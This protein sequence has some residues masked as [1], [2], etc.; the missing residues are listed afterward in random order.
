MSRRIDITHF[1]GQSPR[2]FATGQLIDSDNVRLH[3]DHAVE[4]LEAAIDL[5]G[6]QGAEWLPPGVY[7][8]SDYYDADYETPVTKEWV[9]AHVAPLSTLGADGFKGDFR[10]LVAPTAEYG[11][12][13]AGY[14][15][16]VAA[17]CHGDELCIVYSTAMNVIDERYETVLDGF[18]DGMAAT[19]DATLNAKTG[20]GITAYTLTQ[21][22]MDRYLP[23]GKVKTQLIECTWNKHTA[24]RTKSLLHRTLVAPKN[25]EFHYVTDTYR[26]AIGIYSPY[27]DTLYTTCYPTLAADYP[28]HTMGYFERSRKAGFCLY[29]GTD[30]KLGVSRRFLLLP[31]LV[32][33]TG[34]GGETD[35]TATSIQS[36]IALNAGVQL[37]GRLYGI[38]E[39][40][41]HA[42]ACGTADS[43]A[44]S[45][46]VSDDPRAAWCDT[47]TGTDENFTAIAAF[48]GKIIAFTARSMLTV[49]GQELPFELSYIGAYGCLSAEALA[50]HEKY[51]FFVSDSGVMRYDGTHITALDAPPEPGSYANAALTCIGDLLLLSLPA[52]DGIRIYDIAGGGWSYRRIPS[53]VSLLF[54]GDNR[55]SVHFR[56]VV[57]QD[58]GE[59]A[60]P[61]HLFGADGAFS[62]SVAVGFAGRQ[63][64]HSISVTAAPEKDAVLSVCGA[65]GNVLHSFRGTDGR[66]RTYTA[67]LRNIYI[68]SGVIRLSGR[69]KVR[70]FGISLQTSAGGEL[71]RQI[72]P[73]K[74]TKKG[75]LT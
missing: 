51:L 3:G 70:I 8:T 5:Y 38:N 7:T 19:M 60:R 43:F 41:I 33:L 12:N 74:Q 52:E 75:S 32:E 66:A 4:A 20:T 11:K 9:Y 62:L 23:S 56:D 67:A 42:S 35:Y 29:A 15:H 30:T 61:M 65:S 55:E 21:L 18:D 1:S 46:T 37:Y 39:T 47:V 57:L 6:T 45:T 27:K 58:D 44:D 63:H 48:D 59:G 71:R 16:V 72:A 26:P 68:D 64:V 25:G 22:I 31:A 49:R 36:G 53:G 10:F 28:L 69:G 54:P 50:A 40:Q 17:F 2:R 73:E 14:R 13:T 34:E 24:L